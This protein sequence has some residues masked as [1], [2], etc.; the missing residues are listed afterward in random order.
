MAHL[1]KRVSS[2]LLLAL[3]EFDSAIEALI[4]M[5]ELEVVESSELKMHMI[6]TLQASNQG[7]RAYYDLCERQ[8]LLRELVRLQL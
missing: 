8:I 7:K 2:L 5:L 1:L 6:T 4:A 3:R